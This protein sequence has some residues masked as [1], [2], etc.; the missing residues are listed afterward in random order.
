M[1][2][3]VHKYKRSICIIRMIQ[4]DMDAPYFIVASA[5]HV[6][7]YCWSFCD[8][9]KFVIVYNKIKI[10]L[11][12]DIQQI[13]KLFKHNC[14]HVI[15]LYNILHIDVMM[16]CECPQKVTCAINY[17]NSLLNVRCSNNVN[18]N[19]DQIQNEFDQLKPKYETLVEEYHK[20]YKDY[21]KIKNE[22]I[23]LKSKYKKNEIELCELKIK[24]NKLAEKCDE[25]ELY[26]KQLL[27]K[28]NNVNTV[29]MKCDIKS[30][31]RSLI[32]DDVALI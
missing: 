3:K 27:V 13:V 8:S 10:D 5:I 20:I 4:Y 31:S 26:N 24:Y 12:S 32:G 17:I 1:K 2:F 7:T 14:F 22:F 11:D 18:K 16:L 21:D 15:D 9:S 6:N 19:N 28:Y 25:V 30:N 29:D 23:Q